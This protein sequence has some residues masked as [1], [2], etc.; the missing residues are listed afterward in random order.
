M[1]ASSLHAPLPSLHA[2]SFSNAAV[3]SPAPEALAAAYGIPRSFP[4]A[5]HAAPITSS[6]P[7]PEAQGAV[8]RVF[9]TSSGAWVRF[10]AQDGVWQALEASSSRGSSPSRVL[11][12]VS[13]APIGPQLTWLQ[14]QPARTAKARLHM[15]PATSSP[16]GRASVYL[17]RLGLLG[18]MEAG[19]GSGEPGASKPS[20]SS[21]N[22]SPSKPTRKSVL[23]RLKKLKI[24]E[25]QAVVA[26]Y[27][28]E[29]DPKVKAE[30]AYW[31]R[32]C[33]KRFEKAK[34]VSLSNDGG[35]LLY[36]YSS[37]SD[38]EDDVLL[39]D[40]F[41]NLRLKIKK[42]DAGDSGLSQA[43]AVLFPKLSPSVFSGTL[44]DKPKVTHLH[45]LIEDQ[46]T[47]LSGDV[48]KITSSTYASYR[49]TLYVLHEAL[50]LLPRID[51]GITTAHYA[52]LAGKILALHKAYSSRPHAD[53]YY[54]LSHQL[55]RIDQTFQCLNPEKSD[56]YR[57]NEFLQR[58]AY[59]VLGLACSCQVLWSLVR[60]QNINAKIAKLAV[61]SFQ[62]VLAHGTTNRYPQQEVLHAMNEAVLVAT[63]PAADAQARTEA[64]QLFSSSLE[65]CKAL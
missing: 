5:F 30:L 38:V 28:A 6:P 4:V 56:E 34:A 27:N 50:L 61:K 17:G 57:L 39:F 8:S 53:R 45:L 33:I 51:R 14:D 29:Q 24:K 7:P 63:D 46:L 26:R 44:G 59:G 19:E 52:D 9:P 31:L 15:I 10:E 18:G 55:E 20:S 48:P 35:S 40:Y 47:K 43:M 41:N 3:S 23:R 16:S 12:V 54:P 58:S 65:R 49:P 64:A 25:T 60:E 37:L 11:P 22:R 21:S 62:Q 13:P 32:E 1:S 2:S 36:A 42:S